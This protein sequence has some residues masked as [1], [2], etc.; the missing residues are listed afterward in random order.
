MAQLESFAHLELIL[1]GFRFSGWAD[2]DPPFEF[3]F[4]ESS[5]RTRGADGG[6]YA[7]GMP[8]YGGTFTFK[9]FPT[10]RR[11]NGPCNRSRCARTLTRM[12]NPERIYSGTLVNPGTGVSYR[13]DGGIIA[14]FPAVA[15]PGQTYEGMIDFEEITSLVDDGGT[16]P[17]WL[18]RAFPPLTS[19]GP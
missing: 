1:N 5:E 8:T 15:I 6:L 16:G 19:S 2:E 3:D 9:V 11:R 4:E 10:A 7:L 18:G 14:T 17:F 13:V 12:G